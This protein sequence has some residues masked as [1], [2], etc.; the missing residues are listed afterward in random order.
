[1]TPYELLN[2]SETYALF[3]INDDPE[4]YALKIY[5]KLKEHGKTV[6]GINPKYT[7]VDGDTVYT[8]VLDLPKTPD[9]AVMVVNPRIGITMLEDIKAKGIMKLWLQ[10]GTFDDAF[11]DAAHTLGFETIDACVLAV[12]SIY[13][14]K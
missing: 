1:M 14:K 11:L 10:P 6:W 7:E 4:K 5:R 3:G 9:I 12:Y 8:S 13:D 2:Q